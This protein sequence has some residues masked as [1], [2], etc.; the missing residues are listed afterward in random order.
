MTEQINA[1]ALP[2]FDAAAFLA[3]EATVA[4]CLTDI[5]ADNDAALLASA[6]GDIARP[7]HKWR[8]STSCGVCSSRADDPQ[9]SPA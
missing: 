5:L 2:V 3:D 7:G 1:R 4:G 8:G 9:G 6:P